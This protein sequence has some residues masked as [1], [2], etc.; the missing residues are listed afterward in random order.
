LAKLKI[1]GAGTRE[2]VRLRLA[3]EE[4]KKL[5]SDR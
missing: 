1:A 3:F 2:M 5:A 4:A